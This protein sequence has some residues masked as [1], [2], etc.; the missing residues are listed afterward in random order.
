MSRDGTNAT[1]R[2]PTGQ[3]FDLLS[4]LVGSP[5]EGASAL[6]RQL[7][8]TMV[9]PLDM[10]GSLRLHPGDTIPAVVKRRVP[11]EASYPDA[12]GVVVHVLLHVIDGRLNELE[13]YREDSGRV[14][15]PST[16]TKALDVDLW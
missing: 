12:D 14:L 9:T 13:V 5:F 7:A 11:V 6:A 15:L 16:E 3:E 2:R 1:E 4:T 8:T 10:N